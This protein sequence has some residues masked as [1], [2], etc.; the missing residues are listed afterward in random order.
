M[1]L[2]LIEPTAGE[3]EFEGRDVRALSKS[4]LRGLRRE[5]QIIFQDPY[6]SLN[7]RM[8]VRDIVGEPLVIH[9][10]K[11]KEEKRARVAELLL[12]VG[13]LASR[14]Q[15][16]MNEQIR[17]LLEFANVGDVENVVAAI[18]QVVARA[19]DRAKRRVARRDTRQGN[20]LLRLEKPGSKRNGQA[21]RAWSSARRCYL[22]GVIN[23]FTPF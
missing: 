4:E 7:P 13:E 1:L 18:V 9:G 23:K 17:D 3:I 19:P 6:A 15:R 21:L 12:V 8:K 11:D 16:A 10:L 14:G 2:R 5:M 22:R 20:R